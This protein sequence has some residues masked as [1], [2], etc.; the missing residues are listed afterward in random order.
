MIINYLFRDEELTFFVQSF[1]L[2]YTTTRFGVFEALKKR[3]QKG[4]N[5]PL[6]FLQKVMIGA[7]GGKKM[8]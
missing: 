6:P 8:N 4:S 3:I 7:A 5:E 1:Q 2:S